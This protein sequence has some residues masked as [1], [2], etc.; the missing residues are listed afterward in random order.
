MSE[1]KSS[2]AQGYESCIRQYLDI[3]DGLRSIGIE[4]DI[5][6]PQIV[7]MG[8]Q[9]SG[10]SSVLESLSSIPFPRGTGLV[11]RC[12]IELKMKKTAPGSSWVCKISM[13]LNKEPVIKEN[14]E[15][16]RV[17]DVIREFSDKLCKDDRL[18]REVITVE[19]SA[20]TV[21]DLTLID[22]PGIVRTST[23]GQDASVIQQTN[24][25][26]ERYLSQPRT[27]VLAVIPANVD[28]ATV[29]ILER[30]LKHDPIGDRTV[31]V[32]TKPDLVDVGAE[33]EVLC[34]LRNIKKPLKLGYVMVKNRSQQQIKDGVSL[35]DAHAFEK[36]FFQ[37][38]VGKFSELQK[39]RPALF[40]IS[41]LTKRLMEVLSHRIQQQLPD[42]KREVNYM[43]ADCR[44]EL[45]AM[46]AE[47]P[48]SPYEAVLRYSALINEA[49]KI[50]GCSIKG[51]YASTDLLL[52]HGD[53]RIATKM[54]GVFEKFGKS[55]G[56]CPFL[57]TKSRSEVI[58]HIAASRARELPGFPNQDVFNTLIRQEFS[59]WRHIA[60][61]CAV[62]VQNVLKA[63][64]G[65]ILHLCLPNYPQ[66]RGMVQAEAMR[67]IDDLAAATLRV[68]E[69]D[70]RKETDELFTQDRGFYMQA[71]I[72]RAKERCK[73]KLSRSAV[74]NANTSITLDEVLQWL[75]T[76][77]SSEDSEADNMDALLAA[78]WGK[79]QARVVDT[80]PKAIFQ[81]FLDKV[82]GELSQALNSRT[83]QDLRP[84]FVV[85]W[86]EEQRRQ[87]LKERVQRLTDSANL[88]ASY[89]SE[90]DKS[91]DDREND[92]QDGNKESSEKEE[93]LVANLQKFTYG[94]NSMVFGNESTAAS[95]TGGAGKGKEEKLPNPPVF[96]FKPAPGAPSAATPS[97]GIGF[98]FSTGQK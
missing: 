88:L 45:E 87:A 86:D 90:D 92:V 32:I 33:E 27:I 64:V 78:Y 66:F 81:C 91:W 15:V 47:P 39:Q 96:T 29:D 58:Q 54:R 7:V 71:L 48:Q 77:M 75:E 94:K 59:P 8:D 60:Q 52:R 80:V 49:V 67:V 74:G 42:I 40:G 57:T 73:A 34:V 65:R 98:S 84:L 62:E 23:A 89:W 18:S 93:D 13:N 43:L 3:V 82:A 21:P 70:V 61:D 16:G 31:G 53:V 2:I 35:K 85:S 4:K 6:I 14:V 26:I 72:K 51:D 79:V 11:T 36:E 56:T 55:L 50:V 19:V 30:A 28:I 24:A 20:E 46:G 95:T 37:S 68:V 1:G 69:S 97:F 44:R 10:K 5:P 25:L 9:S 12:P 63:M 76:D 17:E 83:H 22:L 38:S 41:N